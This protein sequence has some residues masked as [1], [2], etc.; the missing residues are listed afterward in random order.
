MATVVT[1]C[2]NKS[3]VYWQE[4]NDCEM[5]EVDLDDTGT[6]ETWE[7]RTADDEDDDG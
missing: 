5:S 7:Q 2:G 1:F 6:C 3:C 4:P